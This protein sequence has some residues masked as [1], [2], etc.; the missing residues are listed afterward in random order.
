MRRDGVAARGHLAVANA[1]GQHQIDDLEGVFGGAGGLRPVA[2]AD[3]QRMA[4]VDGALAAHAGGDR[5]LQQLGHLR[6]RGREIHAAH[7]GV[8]AHAQLAAAQQLQRAGEGG[9]VEGHFRRPGRRAVEAMR[10]DQ[11]VVRHDHGRRPRL[12]LHGELKRLL[13][14][15]GNVADLRD[16]E[17]ALG[18]LLNQPGLRDFMELEW[19]IFVAAGHVADDA[20]HRHAVQERFADAGEGVGD[21]RPRHD[22][23]D[24]GPAGAAGGAVGHARG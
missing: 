4:L 1:D 8:D 19:F 21:A 9:L 22:A 12:A 13:D 14:G 10:F 5:R 6:Q 18:D 24:A 15:A 16:V 7:A 3:R 20:D 2:P 23:D 17:D 11:Q